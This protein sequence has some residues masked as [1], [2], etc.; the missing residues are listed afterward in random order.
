MVDNLNI[1]EEMIYEITIQTMSQAFNN[2]FKLPM[3]DR[4][5]YAK[6]IID[7]GD[8]MEE[9][10]PNVTAKLKKNG[11]DVIKIGKNFLVNSVVLAI[12]SLG[13]NNV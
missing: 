11:I 8:T 13:E 7:Y 9:Y 10:W 12:Q 6:K 3:E 5:W 4:A 2:F 1:I